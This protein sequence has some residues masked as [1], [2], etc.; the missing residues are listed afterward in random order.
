MIMTVESIIALIQS[1]CTAATMN[2]F[3]QTRVISHCSAVNTFSGVRSE[4]NSLKKITLAA[5]VCMVAAAQN[6][7]DMDSISNIGM[8]IV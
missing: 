8:M 7:V 5:T 2:T 3:N 6:I 1:T 4:F